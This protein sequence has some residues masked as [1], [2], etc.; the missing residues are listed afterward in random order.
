MQQVH[1]RRM[2]SMTNDW[3]NSLMNAAIEKAKRKVE[4]A[5]H[6]SPGQRTWLESNPLD[7]YGCDSFRVKL[8]VLEGSPCKG[9]VIA[10]YG[11]MFVTPFSCSKKLRGIDARDDKS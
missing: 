3:K 11:R 6:C 8:F 2:I 7:S 1:L 4:Q 9:Y 5:Y 10:D